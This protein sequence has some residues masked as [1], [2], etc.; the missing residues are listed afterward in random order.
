MRPVPAQPLHMS[1]FVIAPIFGFIQFVSLYAEFSYLFDSVF[2]AN[3]YAMLGFLLLNVL[4]LILTIVLL[5][6]V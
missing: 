6:I 3:W 4:L 2:K 5:S 1:I